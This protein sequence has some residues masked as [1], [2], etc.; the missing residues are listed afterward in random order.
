MPAALVL[1]GLVLTKYRKAATG[2]DRLMVIIG[3]IAVVALVFLVLGLV[4]LFLLVPS[5]GA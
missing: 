2:W 5:T 1:G 3:L 4:A